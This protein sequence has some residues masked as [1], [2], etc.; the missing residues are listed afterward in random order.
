MHKWMPI[1]ILAALFTPRVIAQENSR[2]ELF[3]G[4]Q[5]LHAGSFD[6][7]GDS[8]NTNG[9]DAAATANF[10]RHLGVTADFSGNY[11]NLN[12]TNGSLTANA[13]VRIYTYTFGP[14]ASYPIGRVKVFA[15]ALFGDA[16]VRP[17]GCVA[18]SG[19]PDECGPGSVSGFGMIVGGGLDLRA[20]KASAFRVVQLDWMRLP[21][22]FGAQNN[23]FRVSSGL[24]FHF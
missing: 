7:E 21:S 6:G 8:A 12:A 11:K 15:H 13:S 9:W 18:F 19:S 2:F 17:T 14:T 24:V 4:Y 22:Q 16:H 10:T 20:G 1:A 23:N 3:G 5:F